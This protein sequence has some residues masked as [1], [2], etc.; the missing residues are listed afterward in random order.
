MRYEGPERRKIP[1]HGWRA[2][3][4]GLIASRLWS[5]VAYSDT[6]PTRFML[7]LAATLWAILLA[8]PGDTFSRPVYRF[9][10]V[11]VGQDAEMKWCFFW[12]LHACGMW[13][14]IFS[15]TPRPFWALAIHGLGV[16]LFSCTA[17]AI[18]MTLTYPLPAAIAPD[19]IMALAAGWVLV[20][21]HINP[22]PGW[23]HD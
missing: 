4:Y 19:I 13:W 14:R 6:T 22:E 15:S 23:R 8:F 5:L 17:I 10:A 1:R 12:T 3:W 20:R 16:M 9:M 18:F 21:T 2:T 7:A 11:A